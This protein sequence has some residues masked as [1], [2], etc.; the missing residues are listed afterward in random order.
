MAEVHSPR[1]A[2]LFPGQGAFDGRAL[3]GAAARYPEIGTVFAEID[4][5]TAPVAGR[6]LSEIV[7]GSGPVTI[8]DL[9]A[10][11]PWVS[12]LAI[13]GVDVAVHR[14]LSGLGMRPDVLMGHS[15]GEVAALVCGGVYTVSD[16]A[17]VI[18]QRI[19]AISSLELRGGYMAALSTDAGRAGHLVELLA[20][21]SLAVAVENHSGQTVLSGSGAAMD[22][23]RQ[24]AGVLRLPVAR[25]DSLVPYH[26]PLLTPAVERFA[27]AIRAIPVAPGHSRVYSPIQQRYYTADEDFG[28]ALAEHLVRPVRFDAAVR[29]LS[30]EGVRTFVESGAL[31]TLAKLVTR[32]LEGERPSGDGALIVV[33]ALADADNPVEPAVAALRGAGVLAADPA[34]LAALLPDVVPEQLKAFWGD[35]GPAIIDLVRQEYT[36]YRQTPGASDRGPDGATEAEPAAGSTAMNPAAA[37]ATAAS[38]TVIPATAGAPSVESLGEELRGLYAEALEYPEEVFTDD[39]LLEADLGIDSVKQMELFSRVAERYGLP[40]RPEGFRLADHNTMGKVIQYV[41]TMIDKAG[42]ASAV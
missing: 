22:L 40:A 42:N 5:V 21:D 14:V 32:I 33:S 30:D 7:L 35:R 8:G 4:E 1:T 6:K 26:C 36:A 18:W 3:I 38:Q 31:T 24:V 17:R 15:L 29:R 25:L 20:D 37:A 9:L 11:E 16:G 34:V 2:A 13:Y 10:D 27:D 39:V 12:Q 41:H 28:R 19:A 23:V